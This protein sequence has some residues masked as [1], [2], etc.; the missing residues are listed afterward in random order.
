MQMQMQM[1]LMVEIWRL[2]KAG[3]TTLSGANISEAG[4]V[5]TQG[6]SDKG[7]GNVMMTASQDISLTN[8]IVANWG[9]GSAGLKGT[10]AGNVTITAGGVRLAI[11]QLMVSVA[12][13][14]TQTRGAGTLPAQ[15]ILM[16]L[17]LMRAQ[18]SWL[19]QIMETL[20]SGQKQ[21][22]INS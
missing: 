17:R 20:P 10:N 7:S 5:L 21:Q 3:G 12:E 2:L 9:T 11:F 6:T 16:S 19:L 18:V 4:Q 22:V 13:Q 15:V 1:E 14:G 8:T